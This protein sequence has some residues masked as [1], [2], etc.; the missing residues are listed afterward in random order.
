MGAPT[1]P[2]PSSRARSNPPP[3][4]PRARPQGLEHLVTDKAT[5]V[6]CN[7]QS[8]LDPSLCAIA[9]SRLNFKCPFK[10]DLMY[11]P[12]VGS[13]LWLA[14]H[15]PI[16]RSNKRDG[17]A[18]LNQ[19]AQW[20]QRG[21]PALYFAEGTRFTGAGVGDFKPGAFVLAQ[22]EQAPLQCVT[23]SGARAMLPPGFPSMQWGELRITIHPALPPPPRAPEGLGEEERKAANF[24][25]TEKAMAQAKAL[26]VSGLRDVDWVAPPPKRGGAA[27]AAADKDK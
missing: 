7:H 8:F 22:R 25:A 16:N 3:A 18:L 2:P 5:V 27:A 15:M 20:L 11:V 24:A 21:C 12:G 9:L 19:C 6:V 26:I 14:G 4:S 1:P 17:S 23:I 13:C 10:H